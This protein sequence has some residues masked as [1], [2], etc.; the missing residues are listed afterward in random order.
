MVSLFKD[1]D[2]G[3]GALKSLETAASVERKWG[4]EKGG[5]AKAGAKGRGKW[6]GANLNPSL[7]PPKFVVGPLHP[8]AR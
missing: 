2:A 8:C 6:A 4:K 7:E 5:R 1:P 3:P